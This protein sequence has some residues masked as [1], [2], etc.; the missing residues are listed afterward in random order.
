MP[1][2]KKKEIHSARVKGALLGLALGDAF[3]APYEGGVIERVVWRFI[4]KRAGRYRWTDDTQMTIDMIESLITR[5][6][7][8]PDDLAR[9]FAQS[10]RWSRGYGPGT[11]RV[12]KRIREG[13]PWDVANRSVYREGSLGNGAAMRAPAIGLFFAEA[14]EDELVRET[15]VSAAVTHAH[16]LGCEG[17]A[18]IALA[19]ALA[20]KDVRSDEIIQRLSLYVHSDIFLNKLKAAAAWLEGDNDIAPRTVAS[21]LGNKIAATD[22]CVTAVYLALSHRGKSF[23][24]LLRLVVRVGGDTDTIAAMSCAIWGAM[25]GF[26]GLPRAR[27]EHLEQRERLESLAELFVEAIRHQEDDFI[28]GAN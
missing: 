26:N 13:Q 9:R 23:E 22:S 7:V 12:L 1:L 14:E 20:Y 8:D 24:E 11:A 27:L 18:I 6:C 17:A 16:P 2:V 25:R 4:G 10:Y 21:K 3:G 19:T 5:R 28:N 15:H